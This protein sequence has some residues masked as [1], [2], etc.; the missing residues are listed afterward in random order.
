MHSANEILLVLRR[1]LLKTGE[2]DARL[3]IAIF[4][5][6]VLVLGDSIA[7]A[8]GSDTAYVHWPVALVFVILAA[9]IVASNRG[10]L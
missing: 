7:L 5:L 1:S 10:N 3:A 8:V 9:F 2:M 4:F 6:I